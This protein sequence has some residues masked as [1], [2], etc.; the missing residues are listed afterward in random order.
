M[1]YDISK[2]SLEGYVVIRNFLTKEEHKELNRT[3]KDLTQESKYFSAQKDQWIYNSP[4][5]PCKL[6]GAM[7]Y[8]EELKELGRHKKLVSVAQ[9]LLKTTS[10]GTYISK[11]FPMVPKVGFSVDWHQDN[12]YINAIPDRLVSCDVFVNGATKENGCL[13][14]VPRSHTRGIFKHDKSSHGVF[15]WINLNPKVDIVDVELNEPF[16]V[17]FHPNLIHG[18]YKNTSRDFRYSVA[19]EYMK[20]PYL[21]PTHN[22]HISNDLI[23]IGD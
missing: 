12:Y 14:V 17:F 22:D 8:S 13:R 4:G 16:A 19:W 7:A 1:N 21:P 3:C 20:W 15:N 18:C 6:Q 10:L 11:F 23:H 5:N 9:R 2:F